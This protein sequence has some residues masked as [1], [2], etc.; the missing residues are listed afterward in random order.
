MTVGIRSA[1]S[2]LFAQNN[3]LDQRKAL[4]APFLDISLDV[5]SRRPVKELPSGIPKPIKRRS[6]LINQEASIRTDFELSHELIRI[7]VL[8]TSAARQRGVG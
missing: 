7:E 3:R 2:I 8:T 5:F 6:V 4:R 1:D